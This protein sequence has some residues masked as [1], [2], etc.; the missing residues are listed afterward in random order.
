MLVFLVHM[1]NCSF[2]DLDL[3]AVLTCA[4]FLLWPRD[5]TIKAFMGRLTWS[6]GSPLAH[7]DLVG[8]TPGTVIGAGTIP[9][10]CGLTTLSVPETTPGVRPGRVCD[11]PCVVIWVTG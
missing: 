4:I 9:E 7:V 8:C 11:D 1:V 2:I 5:Q 6:L 3:Q 10:S